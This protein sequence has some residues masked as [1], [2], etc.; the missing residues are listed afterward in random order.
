MGNVAAHGLEKVVDIAVGI[1]LAAADQF[2]WAV[3]ER[4]IKLVLT[5][6]AIYVKQ[7]VKKR[8]QVCGAGPVFVE[9]NLERINLTVA[10][11]RMP[12]RRRAKEDPG[13]PHIG[14]PAWGVGVPAEVRVG[15]FDARVVLFL[16]RVVVR[17]ML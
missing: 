1:E 13:T 6:V 12:R 15:I 10:D 17:A 9:P 7:Q 16:I 5:N 4:A 11:E 14:P 2:H 3:E 8:G